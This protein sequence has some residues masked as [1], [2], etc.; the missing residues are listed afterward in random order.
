MVTLPEPTPPNASS[1]ADEFWTCIRVVVIA[2]LVVGV[3]VIGL[4]SRLIMLLLRLTSPDSVIGATSDDGFTIGEFTLG[5]TYNLLMM[6]MGLG[7]LGAAVYLAI[8]PLLI[9]PLW[10][11]RLCTGVGSGVVVAAIV[12]NRDGVDFIILKPTWLA[13]ALF[14]TLPILF[15]TIVGPVVDRISASRFARTAGRQPWLL[16]VVALT[17]FP[18]SWIVALV[19][20][21][22]LAIGLV[23]SDTKVAKAAQAPAARLMGQAGFAAIAGLGLL[24]LVRDIEA[25]I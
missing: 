1:F 5:G 11:R 14:V 13:I 19:V 23:I 25:I 10:F 17:L 4:G 2:G 20:A 22:A 7:L 3:P 12:I 21:A 15:G 24:A 6:G 16:P 18:L 9:G 8:K